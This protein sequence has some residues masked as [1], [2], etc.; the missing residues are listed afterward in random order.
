MR[1]F[2][3]IICL[4]LLLAACSKEAPKQEMMQVKG[5]AMTIPYVITLAQPYAQEEVVTQLIQEVFNL[6]HNVFDHY[7]PDSEISQINQSSSHEIAIS[8][9]M[10]R[11]LK[12]VEKHYL[13]SVGR[14]DPS[15]ATV[16]GVWKEAFEKRRMPPEEELES[17]RAAVG[18]K[19]LTVKEGVLHKKDLRTQIDLS[20]IAKGDTVDQLVAALKR[21]GCQNFIVDW[22][23][24]I[25]VCGK[26]PSGRAWRLFISCLGDND[27]KNALAIVE[28]QDEAIATSGNYLQQW[29]L[30]GE[31][32][33]H[34]IDPRTLKPLKVRPEAIGSASVKAPSC[35]D[36]DAMATTLMLFDSVEE[37]KKWASGFEVW[38]VSGEK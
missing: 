21:S 14:Y 37:A 11:L 34:I 12:R 6:T 36:A 15:V 33:T 18:W 4:S 26:H 3:K 20:G 32:Y 8:S 24:E 28:M 25:A 9:E 29:E 5:V 22:G 38:V 16:A 31:M 7:N 23:G 30:E 10:E 1:F 17:L 27:P 13:E 35:A 2:I 19:N